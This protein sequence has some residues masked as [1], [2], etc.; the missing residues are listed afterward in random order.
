MPLC[1]AWVCSRNIDTPQLYWLDGR[2]RL[3]RF[4]KYI[5]NITNH[6]YW[7]CRNHY[8][9]DIHYKKHEVVVIKSPDVLMYVV[10]VSHD[11]H[12]PEKEEWRLYHGHTPHVIIYQLYRPNLNRDDPRVNTQCVLMGFVLVSPVEGDVVSIFM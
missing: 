9:R 3:F 11:D 6:I 5:I 7:K 2:L 8:L 10:V 4:I 12:R 1:V